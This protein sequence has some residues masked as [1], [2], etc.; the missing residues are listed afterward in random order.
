MKRI[1]FGW[2]V[3]V[4]AGLTG[5][6]SQ[7]QD[8][9]QPQSYSA[10]I[11]Y[12]NVPEAQAALTARAEGATSVGEDGWTHVREMITNTRFVDWWFAP[13]SD[14]AYPTAI[15][16]RQ[17]IVPGHHFD[18]QI[19]CEAAIEKCDQLVHKR[20]KEMNELLDELEVE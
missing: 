20:Q 11:G 13:A 2:I 6:A 12:A 4:S 18:R 7:S 9:E 14:P 10:S 3:C 17:D 19:R 8:L 15:F 1:L 16:V 5:C